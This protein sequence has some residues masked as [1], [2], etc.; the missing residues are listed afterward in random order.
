VSVRETTD[1]LSAKMR[2]Q[3]LTQRDFARAVGVSEPTVWRWRTGRTA[4]DS[5]AVRRRIIEVL[6]CDI[7]EIRNNSLQNGGRSK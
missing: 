6:G 3:G 1:P 2:E 7:N 5:E 4:P